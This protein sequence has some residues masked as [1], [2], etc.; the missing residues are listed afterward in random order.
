M[1]SGQE[2]DLDTPI[3]LAD[4]IPIAFPY[5]GIK[6]SGLKS[7]IRN[8]RLKVIR[9]AGKDFTTLRY[10]E[11]MKSKCIVVVDPDRR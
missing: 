3:R 1:A 2:T 4:V 5:G 6:L 11:E 9:I 10:I 7:E 8:G